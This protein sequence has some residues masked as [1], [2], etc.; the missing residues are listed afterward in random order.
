MGPR[1]VSLRGRAAIVGRARVWFRRVGVADKKTCE[2]QK[3][4]SLSGCLEHD[5][6]ARAVSESIGEDTVADTKGSERGFHAE[7]QG[8][9]VVGWLGYY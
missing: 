5:P 7:M 9:Y 6:F 3:H 2:V 1:A 8:F 4:S